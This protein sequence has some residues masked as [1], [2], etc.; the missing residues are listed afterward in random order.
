V[1][2]TEKHR[3]QDL[4]MSREFAYLLKPVKTRDY[5]IVRGGKID[6]H[7]QKK[8]RVS[9]KKAEGPPTR[10]RITELRED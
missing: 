1:S 8:L 3:G 5:F 4:E 10:N 7:I 6:L 2:T 9:F